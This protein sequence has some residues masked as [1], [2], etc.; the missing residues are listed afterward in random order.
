MIKKNILIVSGEFHPTQ[1]PRSF[2]TTELAKE[3]SKQGNNVTVLA[4]NIDAES[5]RLADEFGLKVDNIELSWSKLFPD[6][7]KICYMLNRI[8]KFF[9]EYPDIQLALSLRKKLKKYSNYDV[10]ISIAQPF[11]IHWGVSFIWDKFNKAKNPAKTWVADCGDPYMNVKYEKIPKPFYFNLLE[12]SFLDKADYV[13]VPFED[14]IS[15]FNSNYRY[16]FEVIPQGF[17]L[18]V[19]DLPEYKENEIPTFIYSGTIIP[20]SRDP[21]E[22]I[23]YLEKKK[24]DYKFIIYTKQKHQLQKYNHLI[25]NKIYVRDYVKRDNLLESLSKVDFLV[26]ID[27]PKSNGKTIAVPTKLIDYR[28]SGR[29]ILSYCYTDFPKKVVDEFMR[30]KYDNAYVDENFE[31]FNIKN[32]AKEFLR[33]T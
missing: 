30:G 8:F 29:P 27:L 3:L 18:N 7:I 10:L 26:N 25:G 12:R 9:L 28:I 22:L 17:N 13:T 33:L 16:K 31:R 1:S 14:M 19:S 4:P 32:V 6:D 20:G 2:R 21:F 5:Y 11:P 24:L 15:L 23:D